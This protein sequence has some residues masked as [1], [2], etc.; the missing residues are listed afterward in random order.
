MRRGDRARGD[1]GRWKKGDLEGKFSCGFSR[2]FNFRHIQIRIIRGFKNEIEKCFL[3]R[4][5]RL[6][7]GRLFH[8]QRATIVFSDESTQRG[9]RPQMQS[10]TSVPQQKPPP[11]ELSHADELKI[12][13]V[14]FGYLLS[15]HFW[16]DGDYSAVFLQGDDHEVDALIQKFS[17]HV[18]PI[19]PGYDADLPQNRSPVDKSIGQAGDDFERGRERAERGRF[20]GCARQMVC[21]RR[22]D[23]ILQVL[24]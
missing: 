12:R 16:D 5:V 22:G 11:K 2:G 14:V 15:R 1:F 18:P 10:W 6:L 17:G 9:S 24:F 23:G 13:E 20:R 21:G 3:R 4:I 8:E 7:A 19:K